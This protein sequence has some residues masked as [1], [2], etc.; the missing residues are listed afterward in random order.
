LQ[1]ITTLL[2]D[3]D[4]SDPSSLSQIED[5]LR[6][7]AHSA[8]QEQQQQQFYDEAVAA[9]QDGGEPEDED[10][11]DE[12]GV[13]RA[14]E[15]WSLSSRSTRTEQTTGSTDATSVEGGVGE[16][17]NSSRKFLETLFPLM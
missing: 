2:F 17:I 11:E 14:L 4:P 13:Q 12:A 15:E 6:V 9:G 3:L 8:Q 10:E 7:L 1:L 5:T 16:D